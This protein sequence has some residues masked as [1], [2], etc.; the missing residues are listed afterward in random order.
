MMKKATLEATV[1]GLLHDVGKLVYRSGTAGVDHSTLG[2]EFLEHRAKINGR[3]ILDCVCYHHSDKLK[4]AGIPKDSP[5]YIVYIADNIASAADRRRSDEGAQ[6]GFNAQMPLS[7]VFSTLA[8]RPGEFAYDAQV[9]SD[10]GILYPKPR[11]EA[12][13]TREHYSKICQELLGKLAAVEITE[14]FVNSLLA[15]AEVCFSYVPASTDTSELQDISLFDHVKITAAVA[16][17]ISEYCDERNI[18]N[19]RERL[20]ER[21][22]QFYAEKA[23]LMY[24]CDISGI[25]NFIYNIPMKG[26]LKSLRSRS[27]ALELLMEHFIDEILEGCGLSRANLIYSGGGHCYMLLPNTKTAASVCADREAAMKKW[28]IENFGTSLYIASAY[29]ECSGNDLRNEPA[30]KTPYKNIFVGLAQKISEKKMRRYTADELRYLN[31]RH[32][33]GGTRECKVCGRDDMLV[34]WRGDE[35][36]DSLEVCRSCGMFIRLGSELVGTVYMPVT[37]TKLPDCVSWELPS[38]NG[39]VYIGFFK[40][41]KETYIRELI[42]SGKD[43]VRIYTKNKHITGLKYARTLYMGDYCYKP[44]LGELI[45]SLDEIGEGI[46]RIAVLRADV[47]NLGKAFISGF[48]KEGSDDPAERYKFVTLSRTAAFS[49]QMSTFF[50][51]FVNHILCGEG[52]IPSAALR[53]S[54]KKKRVNI[55]YSGGDD[56]FIVGLWEDVLAA[57]LEI[58]E[59]FAKYCSGALTLSAGIGIFDVKFPISVSARVTG[60]L[61]EKAKEYVSTTGQAKNA[62]DLFMPADG[63]VFDW[64]ELKDKVL[65]EKFEAVKELLEYRKNAGET[66]A[67]RGTALLYN[68]LQLL[69]ESNE[70]INI[71]RYAYLLSKLKPTEGADSQYKS[72]YEKLA[73]KMYGWAADKRDR[74]ELLMAITIY[75]Y[76]TRRRA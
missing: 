15:V 6:K 62:V 59:A 4:Y 65:R 36:D 49:R 32:L 7:S 76:M 50:R 33:G 66:T 51:L 60:E 23:F 42:K 71:A 17:C 55:V 22:E 64:N 16:A 14:D 68:I 74:D 53:D 45:D 75:L 1:G 2:V 34:T 57:A 8:G 58:R 29:V 39:S 19:L 30:D 25:Q 40:M 28:L 10:T 5:A 73:P 9:F 27:F 54:P 41:D 11:A 12:V 26:A 21:A 63:Y 20:Y 31:S 52:G 70:K 72:L 3:E 56:M 46:S 61:E 37:R 48:E 24:S 69:R 13:V 47:D 44:N 35:P 18:T 38:A 43:I 67:E